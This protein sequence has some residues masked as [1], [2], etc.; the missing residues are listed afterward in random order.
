VPN[1]GLVD[2]HFV[3]IGASLADIEQKFWLSVN[4]TLKAD[5][6][7]QFYGPD[8]EAAE[9]GDHFWSYYFDRSGG[10]SRIMFFVTG[11]EFPAGNISFSLVIHYIP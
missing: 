3:P 4:L 8:R 9:S 1:P 10:I 2:T 7:E 11:P 5:G 6:V